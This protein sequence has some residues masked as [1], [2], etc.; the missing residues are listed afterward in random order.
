[1]LSAENTTGSPICRQLLNQDIPQYDHVCTCHTETHFSTE[2][3]S[4]R[5]ALRTHAYQMQQSVFR[6]RALNYWP[7]L[8]AWRTAIL[9]GDCWSCYRPFYQNGRTTPS[10]GSSPLPSTAFIITN[11]NSYCKIYAAEKSSLSML[12]RYRHHLPLLDVKNTV[13]RIYG[14]YCKMGPQGCKPELVLCCF[15]KC[16]RTEPRLVR[17]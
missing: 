14:Y 12:R 13:M 2:M 3:S 10:D 9:Y 4:E 8:R 1:M 7:Q 11:Q 17:I 5:G 15:L 16:F 6:L